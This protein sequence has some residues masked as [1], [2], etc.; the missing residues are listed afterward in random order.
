MS[1]ASLSA[2][3]A[4]S[5]S[6]ARNSLPLIGCGA[7]GARS[8]VIPSRRQPRQHSS[9]L[10]SLPLTDAA[11]GADAAFVEGR[12]DAAQA[13]YALCPK[14]LDNRG[15][16]RSSLVGARLASP[17]AAWRAFGW[18]RFFGMNFA[19]TDCVD[20]IVSRPAGRKPVG[21]PAIAPRRRSGRDRAWPNSFAARCNRAGRRRAAA[22]YARHGQ[23]AASRQQRGRD[24][25][26][27]QLDGVT[28]LPP[29]AVLVGG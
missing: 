1:T 15:K 9:H 11:R 5:S 4:V 3:L 12:C 26:T 14:R 19:P 13:R 6:A 29:A 21:E 2:M 28:G 17:L 27:T 18:K 22:L 7:G 23:A 10:R 25:S 16:L 8:I 24:G 20:S